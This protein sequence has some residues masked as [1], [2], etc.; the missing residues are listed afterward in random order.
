MGMGRIVIISAIDFAR[1]DDLDRQMIVFAFENS[2]LDGSGLGTKQMRR[3]HVERILHVSCRM[4]RRDVETLEVV[5]VL[6][7]FRPG[8]YGVTESLHDVSNLMH[9]L[10]HWVKRPGLPAMCRECYVNALGDFLTFVFSL[11]DF[12]PG[13]LQVMLD[14]VAEGIDFL[15]C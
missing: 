7:D 13:L 15:A 4:P 6:F 10:Q 5:V 2:H 9:S 3:I 1:A 14:F 12:S 11:A 8:R